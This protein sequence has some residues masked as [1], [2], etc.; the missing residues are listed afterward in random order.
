MGMAATSRSFAFMGASF[1][2]FDD[3]GLVVLDHH[4]WDVPGLLTQLGLLPGA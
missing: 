4:F 2:A 3:D 1:S